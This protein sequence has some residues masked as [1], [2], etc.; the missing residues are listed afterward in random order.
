[1]KYLTQLICLLILFTGTAYGFEI[2]KTGIQATVSYTEPVV[3]VDKDG[4]DQPL[5]DL[6]HTTIFLDGIVWV[7]FSAAW[8]FRCPSYEPRRWWIYI[9]TGGYSGSYPWYGVQHRFLGE[10]YRS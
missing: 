10:S 8:I 1:M 7:W 3:S 6:G 2:T 4:V 5:N 9:P